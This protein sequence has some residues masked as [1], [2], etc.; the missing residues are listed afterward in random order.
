MAS[1]G[2]ES[3]AR[4]D[5]HLRVQPSGRPLAAGRGQRPRRRQLP[6]DHPRGH[7]PA[8]LSAPGSQRSRRQY[9]PR[10]DSRANHDAATE[11]PRHRRW[12]G[13]VTLAREQLAISMS[14]L[15]RFASTVLFM[16]LVAHS[17]LFG[18]TC[19]SLWVTDPGVEGQVSDL[20][21]RQITEQTDKSATYPTRTNADRLLRDCTSRLT[22][23]KRGSGCRSGRCL[24]RAPLRRLRVAVNAIFQPRL[25]GFRGAV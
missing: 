2:Q 13:S 15:E 3:E 10:R 23:A 8:D 1:A 12:A 21:E 7:R 19:S 18:S 17:F 25:R 16:L 22:A 11:D 14:K 24:P 5:Q 20:S 9:R 6:L 4:F